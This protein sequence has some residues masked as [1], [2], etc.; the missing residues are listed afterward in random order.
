VRRA[1]APVATN[2]QGQLVDF[3]AQLVLN[4]SARSSDDARAFEKGNY[5]WQGQQSI[6]GRLASDYTLSGGAKVAVTSDKLLLQYVT[7]V[8]DQDFSVTITLPAHGR[9]AIELP[10]DAQ[11]VVAADHPDVAAAV[12]V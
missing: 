3:L 8:P 2:G 9:R 12:G 1:L 5:T 6:N 7:R 11:T 10:T 4:L